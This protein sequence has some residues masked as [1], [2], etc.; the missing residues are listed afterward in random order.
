[1]PLRRLWEKS[2]TFMEGLQGAENVEVKKQ[3]QKKCKNYF[4]QFTVGPP[5]PLNTQR[6]IKGHNPTNRIG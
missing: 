5:S 3:V 2:G 4:Y 1:M 6:Y